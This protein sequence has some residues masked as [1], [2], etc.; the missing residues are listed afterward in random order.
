MDFN[1]RSWSTVFWMVKSWAMK[2]GS[3]TA[4]HGSS[5]W[6]GGGGPVGGG[7]TA[8][9]SWYPMAKLAGGGLEPQTYSRIFLECFIDDII[10]PRGYLPCNNSAVS[11]LTSCTMVSTTILELG[12][13]IA[14]RVKWPRFHI[15][16]AIEVGNFT[17][18]S[19]INGME[20]LPETGVE[21][22][23]DVFYY[24]VMVFLCCS[25]QVP[26]SEPPVRLVGLKHP[27]RWFFHGAS[28]PWAPFIF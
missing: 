14:G 25:C 16:N 13:D 15:I 5:W 22:T 6:H 7:S 1:E 12:S 18:S 8:P 10:V 4:A 21:F 3:S 19:F 20:W 9:T 2:P 23:P 26:K 17:V 28:S 11:T 27:Y 24:S